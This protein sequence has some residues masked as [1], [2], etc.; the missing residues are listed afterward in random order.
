MRL[1]EARFSADVGHD[2][3]CAERLKPLGTANCF[4]VATAWIFYTARS[5]IHAHIALSAS[6][7]S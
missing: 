2:G 7:S 1:T 6:G 3:L 5:R 4:K